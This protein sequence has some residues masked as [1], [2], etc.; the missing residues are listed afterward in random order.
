MMQLS[1]AVV[2]EIRFLWPFMQPSPKNC[3]GSR[4]A[5]TASLPCSDRTVSFALP[6][7]GKIPCQRR[8]TLSKDFLILAEFEDRFP[9]AHLAKKA[10]LDRTDSRLASSPEPHFNEYQWQ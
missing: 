10:V 4:I 6:F 2:V 9:R 8:V 3:P 5:M 7:E 1:I